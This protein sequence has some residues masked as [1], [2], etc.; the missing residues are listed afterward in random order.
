VIIAPPGEGNGPAVGI[1]LEPGFL[2]LTKIQD[3]FF[4]AQSGVRFRS[5]SGEDG[6]LLLGTFYCER[7]L[8]QCNRSGIELGGSSYY[9]ADTVL[10]RNF[11]FGTE[12]A[13]ISATGFAFPEL[14][15]TGNTITPQKGD[16][17]VVGTGGVRIADN[18]IANI[19]EDAEN[20]IR[21]VPGLLP[22]ALTPV[23]V[24]GNRLQNLQ[25]NGIA[26]ETLLV[27]AKIEHNVLNAIKGNG[28]IMLA[29]SAAGSMSVLANELINVANGTA[30]ETRSV[31]LAAIHLRQVFL[32]A[33]SDN[34]ISG[35]GHNAVLATVVAGIRADLGLDLRVSD[36]TIVNLAAPTDF[37]NL[38]AGV[39]I[40]APLGHIDIVANLIRRQLAPND[41]SSPW[42]AICILGFGREPTGKFQAGSF[43]NLSETGHLNT[44]STLAAKGPDP[45]R[46]GVVNNTCHGY[47]QGPISQL[48]ITGSCRF[49]DNQYTCVSE[50]VGAVVNVTAEALIA[51]ENRIECGRDAR[52]LDVTLGN[53]KALTV[54]GN[55]VG[56]PIIIN[57][58][59]LGAPWQP[60][61]VIGT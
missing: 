61:N 14:E 2:L 25:G 32:G 23:V 1:F 40:V 58:A 48:L 20:G 39:L 60:L 53:A 42:E 44:V 9:T 56:G 41:D 18:R 52:S 38:A 27:S 37:H 33:V 5:K 16:G 12:G 3:N 31:E 10:A 29:G 35:I 15:I 54:L 8:L 11:I 4:H 19:G 6:A 49:S 13:G 24:S 51:A 43:K 59:A 17:I 57:G 28:V 34:V 46:A 45:V 30:E 7:N 55:I 22:V 47:G 21:L 26:I 36:N 50:K